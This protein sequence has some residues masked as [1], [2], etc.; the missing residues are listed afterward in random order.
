MGFRTLIVGL[1]NQGENWVRAAL[2]SK[3]LDYVGI[4]DID[5]NKIRDMQEKY[6][7]PAEHSFTDL[8]EAIK[9][10]KPDFLIDV[11]PPQLHEKISITA[12]DAGLHVLGEKPI[13]YDMEVAKRMIAYAEKTN[14]TYMVSQNYRFHPLV[15]TTRRLI[16]EGKIGTPE[17][18]NV[19]FFRGRRFPSHLY[20]NWIDDPLVK[21]MSIHHFDLMRYVLKADPV[22]VYAVCKNPTWSWFKGDTL[23]TSVMEFTNGVHVSYQGCWV[24]TGR[25]STLHG[26]WRIEGQSGGL[27][28]DRD[29]LTYYRGDFQHEESEEIPLDDMPCQEQLY[30]I[31]EFTSALKENRAPECEGKDNIKSLAILM[32][33][34]ES[35]RRKEKVYIEEILG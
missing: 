22:S 16:D 23:V 10:A 20:Y 31:H 5:E 26:D 12:F 25:Q 18:A 21:E 1:G 9:A 32:A 29:R 27:I 28:W 35:I 13:S 34:L 14:R 19:T 8:N 11:T 30:S 15:R 24:G 7:I 2:Q 3:E 33:T 6:R 4:V 17:Y